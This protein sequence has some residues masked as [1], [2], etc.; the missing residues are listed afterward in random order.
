MGI[1]LRLCGLMLTVV[2]AGCATSVPR[3]AQVVTMSAQSPAPDS[4]FPA[5]GAIWR[6]DGR[7]FK[8]LGPLPAEPMSQAVNAVPE[9]VS[10]PPAGQSYG[11]IT[12]PPPSVYFG[13][14]F[15]L[16]YRSHGHRSR[17]SYGARRFRHR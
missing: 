5:E 2:A 10:R 15:G 8:A 9:G 13:T 11:Y 14:W 1:T 16:T 12:P 7:E 17:H 4:A 6:L 3:P